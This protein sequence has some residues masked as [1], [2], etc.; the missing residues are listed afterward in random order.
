[1]NAENSSPAPEISAPQKPVPSSRGFSPWLVIACLALGLAGWQWLE[2]RQRLIDVQQEAARRLAEADAIV[3]EMRGAQKQM[4]EQVEGLQGRLGVI[5]GKLN[6]FQGQGAALQNLYQEMAR[7]REELALLEVEQSIVLAAQQLQLA[8]NVPVALLALQA[9]DAQLARLDQPAHLPLRKALAADIERLKA[10]PF[11][12][13]AGI[14]LRLEQAVAAI[15][16]LPLAAQ[17][18]PVEAAPAP[19][20]V[21]QDQPWW[22]VTLSE[23]WREL[24]G[25]V[26]IQRFDRAE[27][28]LLAPGQAYFL[29]ENLKLRLLNAR[30]ALFAHEQTTFRNEL[31]TTADGLERYFDGESKAVQAS[32]QGL[33]ELAAMQIVIELPSLTHSQKAMAAL[34]HG[35]GQP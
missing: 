32:L 5:D 11:A 29:R 33:R 27:P 24:R 17:G 15:D 2:S 13:I 1:M 16:T 31:K 28:P 18:H 34:R 25:L 35:K 10:L 4:V 26:R 8:G 14:S 3:K 22:S 21:M 19:A 12:D 20:E 9:A 23:A 7:G 6:D 30:L